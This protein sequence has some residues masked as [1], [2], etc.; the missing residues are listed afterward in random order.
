[1]RR[2]LGGTTVTFGINNLEDSKPPFSDT[3]FGYD[4]TTANPIG[5]YFYVELEN[6]F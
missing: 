3:M 1:M 2:C 5:R 4:E 6:K